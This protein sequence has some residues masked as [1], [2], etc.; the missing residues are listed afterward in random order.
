MKMLWRILKIRLNKPVNKVEKTNRLLKI[1]KLKR[2]IM[3]KNQLFQ[4]KQMK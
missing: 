1:N 4:T 2:L 3:L